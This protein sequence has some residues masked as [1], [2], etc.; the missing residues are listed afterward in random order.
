MIHFPS[1]QAFPPVEGYFS[2]S[3]VSGGNKAKL[4]WEIRSIASATEEDFLSSSH[5]RVLTI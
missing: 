5:W 3:K 2:A 1:V 4:R